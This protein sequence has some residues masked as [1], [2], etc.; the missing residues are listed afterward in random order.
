MSEQRTERGDAGAAKTERQLRDE[1]ILRQLRPITSADVIA[2]GKAENPEAY[3]TPLRDAGA[4]D[5]EKL[6]G[7]EKAARR[8]SC[9][10]SAYTVA[11]RNAAPA[12]LK[13]LEE[14]RTSIKDLLYCAYKFDDKPHQLFSCI[15]ELAKKIPSESTSEIIRLMDIAYENVWSIEKL[16]AE[17]LRLGSTLGM[18]RC[19]VG[20]EGTEGG[21]YSGGETWHEFAGRLQKIADAA[22]NT[23][24]RCRVCG[25]SPALEG[26]CADCGM[27]DKVQSEMDRDRE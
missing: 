22:M 14:L 2:L 16:R 6:K 13:E 4:I 12:L 1:S 27:D 20:K 8:G 18:I 26:L 7:L 19:V 3:A 9:F 10:S 11:L 21:S 17:N 15:K 24:D 5:I 25:V 23:E